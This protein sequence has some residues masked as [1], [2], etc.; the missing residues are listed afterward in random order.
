MPT[1]ADE[2]LWLRLRSALNYNPSTGE[3]TW[4]VRKGRRR[5]GDS[6]GTLNWRNGRRYLKFE[7]H[8]LLAYRW[9]W[10]YMTSRWPIEIDHIDRNCLNDKWDNLREVSH[11][12]NIANSSL[13][14]DPITGRFYNAD[15]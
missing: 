11:S 7:Q 8:Q 14:N 13:K 5:V 15:L 2:Q 6:A 4:L 9:A 12:E 10:F 3:W 1:Y